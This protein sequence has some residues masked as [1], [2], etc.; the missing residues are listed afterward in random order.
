MILI[1]R[2]AAQVI[3]LSL[4]VWTHALRVMRA[5]TLWREP[6]H[7]LP[8]L[9]ARRARP[10][11]LRVLLRV[12]SAWPDSFLVQP[13]QQH[14]MAVMMASLPLPGRLYASTASLA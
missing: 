5:S 8:A 2:S 1:V 9:Q 10:R 3:M 11:L 4:L 13:S 12:W 6:Q 7:A 14:A